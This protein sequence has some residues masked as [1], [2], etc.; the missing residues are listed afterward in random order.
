MSFPRDLNEAMSSYLSAIEEGWLLLS[1]AESP[2]ET[3]V[4]GEWPP[5]MRMMQSPAHLEMM[6]PESMEWD[7]MS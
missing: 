3:N 1:L 2:V 7:S 4:K 6:S 5:E